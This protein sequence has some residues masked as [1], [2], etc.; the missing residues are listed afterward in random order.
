MFV[1][2][3]L[4]VLQLYCFIIIDFVFYGSKYTLGSIDAFLL[5]LN[6]LQVGATS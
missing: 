3:G 4:C 5:S 2:N 6:P 1:E